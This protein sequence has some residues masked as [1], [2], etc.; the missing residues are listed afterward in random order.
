M[1]WLKQESPYERRI[2]ELEEESE[3]VRK[4]MQQLMKGAPVD[5]LSKRSAA[6][7]STVETAPVRGPRIRSSV[8]MRTR[9]SMPEPSSLDDVPFPET[10]A[11]PAAVGDAPQ[12]T[13][14]RTPVRKQVSPEQFASYLA[15]G[16]F[17]K[18]RSL[19]RERRLQR[20]K[21][22]MMLVFALLAVY[23][24]YIWMKAH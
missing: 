10:D 21:A 20:N 22:I 17:G 9:P 19:S 23:S 12:N 14:G 3:R 7:A 15:S 13:P 1:G 5:A 18:P 2:R 11:A 16:S 4:S 6:P 24:L 8:D